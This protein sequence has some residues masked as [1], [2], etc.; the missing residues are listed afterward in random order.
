MA[1]ELINQSEV[2]VGYVYSTVKGETRKEQAQVLNAINST[3]CV[4]LQEQLGKTLMVKNVVCHG[5]EMTNERTGERAPAWRVILI[6]EDG[7]QYACV[8]K[9][10]VGSLNKIFGVFGTPETWTD[11]L[12]LIARKV[13][14]KRGKSLILE[15]DETAL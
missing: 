12:P 4:S 7:T 9:G 1:Y 10:V 3:Q 14:A 8:S 13:Q 2:Q 5:V 11:P 6:A 15:V